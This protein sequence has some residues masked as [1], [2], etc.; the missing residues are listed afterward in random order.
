M[1]WFHHKAQHTKRF[2]GDK[3]VILDF[4]SKADS[5]LFAYVV[6]Q[7]HTNTWSYGVQAATIRKA[8]Q[9]GHTDIEIWLMANPSE[10]KFDH[11]TQDYKLLPITSSN[12]VID[13]DNFKY[14]KGETSEIRKNSLVY[15]LRQMSIPIPTML[16]ETS[17]YS[18]HL[19]YNNDPKA[20]IQW[21]QDR[22]LSM[23]AAIAQVPSN[24]T[25]H[26][27]E[28]LKAVGIDPSYIPQS[29]T[30]PKY[31]VP[32]SVNFGKSN[33]TGENIVIKGWHLGDIKLPE[34]Y[35]PYTDVFKLRSPDQQ[36][37][38]VDA[39]PKKKQIQT[40]KY[41]PYFFGHVK[42]AVPDQELA[43]KLTYYL[44]DNYWLLKRNI[45][46]IHQ[47]IVGDQLGVT[48]VQ[49]SRIISKLV[50]SQC[51]TPTSG[52]LIGYRAKAYGLGPKLRE[53]LN[54]E[55]VDIA[56]DFWLPYENGQSWLHFLED[57]RQ[58]IYK[59]VSLQD[60][61]AIILEKQDERPKEKHR[62]PKEITKTYEMCLDYQHK[63][64][65]QVS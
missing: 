49:M 16:I 43:R 38:Q 40:K 34:E 28:H 59:G 26:F 10:R 13:L 39:T 3:D 15:Y 5:K 23:L 12:I 35:I 55:F 18:Y 63:H 58:A 36:P 11:R 62:S 30:S 25:D 47:K 20:G 46:R 27:Y 48:Q 2:N 32:G 4:L 33:L 31:R 44:S 50:E 29:L 19:W 60:I 64:R 51:L 21:N 56:Y 7:P 54:A 37:K 61:T 45:L 17:P 42:S 14:I 6:H 8:L 1:A 41:R 57:I 9:N 53:S 22:I 65:T 52:Y 24:A